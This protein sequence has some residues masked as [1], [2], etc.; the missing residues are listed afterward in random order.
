MVILKNFILSAFL[1]ATLC[2]L[3]MVL[4]ALWLS[5]LILSKETMTLDPY[6]G[7]QDDEQDNTKWLLFGTWKSNLNNQTKSET[8]TLWVYLMPQLKWLNLMEQ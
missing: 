6:W 3:L 2:L 4:T 5:R 7:V 8:I 1:M